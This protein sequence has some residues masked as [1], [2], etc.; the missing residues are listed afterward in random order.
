MCRLCSF[1]LMLTL[2]WVPVYCSS[3]CECENCKEFGFVL[4]PAF[5]RGP[6]YYTW[7]IMS[8][9]IGARQC[10]LTPGRRPHSRFFTLLLLCSWGSSVPFFNL[11]GGPHIVQQPDSYPFLSTS[12]WNGRCH[13]TP[14]TLPGFYPVF[15]LVQSISIAKCYLCERVEWEP[16]RSKV[17]GISCISMLMMIVQ[18]ISIA[19]GVALF[20]SI[21]PESRILH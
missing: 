11:E 13:P 1:L 6:T 17:Q 10:L 3:R 9:R 5:D 12:N 7:Q 16:L 19:K 18:S 14:P 15:Q 2:H 4:M 20:V 21:N 8:C